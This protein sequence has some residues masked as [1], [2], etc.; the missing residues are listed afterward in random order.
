MWVVVWLRST[1][2][3]ICVCYA[4]FAGFLPTGWEMGYN[5]Y[6]GRLGMKMP[7]TA[8]LL[9]RS[10]PEWQ[11]GDARWEYAPCAAR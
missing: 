8:A 2:A 3:C 6:V 10:W 11:V 4:V 1:S 7:E 9:A 5:H